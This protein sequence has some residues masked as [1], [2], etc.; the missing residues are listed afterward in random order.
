MWFLG[1]LFVKFN[2]ESFGLFHVLFMLGMSFL[3]TQPLGRPPTVPVW[4][5]EKESKDKGQNPRA[6]KCV[7]EHM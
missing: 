7:C 2:T 4:K 5:D 1:G 6:H 3:T